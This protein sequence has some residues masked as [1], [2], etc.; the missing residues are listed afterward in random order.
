MPAED[1][2]R[3]KSSLSSAALI[4]LGCNI[5]GISLTK[6]MAFFIMLLGCCLLMKKSVISSAFSVKSA[7]SEHKRQCEELGKW[8]TGFGTSVER[9]T[10][11]KIGMGVFKGFYFNSDQIPNLFC[12][13]LF[14]FSVFSQ[15]IG[16]TYVCHFSSHGCYCT[17]FVHSCV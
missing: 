15:G 10:V 14:F 11:V 16:M 4:Q 13:V 1:S 7:S 2:R 5:W 12:K 17:S 3:R 9:L 6:S 8:D